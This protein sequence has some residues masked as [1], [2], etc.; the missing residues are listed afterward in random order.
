MKLIAYVTVFSS[1]VSRI[2]DANLNKTMT[3]SSWAF[4]NFNYQVTLKVSS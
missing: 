4:I 1:D 2:H 3:P